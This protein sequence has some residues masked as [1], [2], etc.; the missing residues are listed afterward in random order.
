MLTDKQALF[1]EEYL[2]D[3]NAS[4]AARRAG[5]SPDTAAAIGH[6]NLR[7]PEIAAAIEEAQQAHIRSLGITRERVLEELAGIAFANPRA[8]MSWG[9]GGVVLRPSEELTDG[10]AALVAEV[11]EGKDGIK[12]KLHSKLG[13]LDKLFKHLGLDAPQK[14][15]HAGKDGGPIKTEA[16]G[17]DE[18]ARRIAFTLARA[19]LAG[20]KPKD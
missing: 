14:H 13:A 16:V 7:K 8:V 19:T 4:A 6:E 18:L 20:S 17:N 12:C 9:P 11:A 10:E 15:E 5:Y 1:I 2:V 3:M